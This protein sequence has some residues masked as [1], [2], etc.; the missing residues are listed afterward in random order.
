MVAENRGL[1][2]EDRKYTKGK[3]LEEPPSTVDNLK[4]GLN[5]VVDL[6]PSLK[7][8]V[9]TIK[10]AVTEQGGKL[11]TALSELKDSIQKHAMDAGLDLV[12]KTLDVAAVFEDIGG[13]IKTKLSQPQ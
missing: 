11:E 7:S 5:Y 2:N 9:E 10:R 4:F 1:I 13:E 3:P 12:S 8:R 6:V